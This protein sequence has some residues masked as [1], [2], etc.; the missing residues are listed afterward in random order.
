MKF[1]GPKTK[2]MIDDF[3]KTRIESLNLSTRTKNALINSSIRTIGGILRTG[4]SLMSDVD[5][6]GINGINEIKQVLSESFEIVVSNGEE[7]GEYLQFIPKYYESDDFVP[8][9][10]SKDWFEKKHQ[11]SFV[12]PRT[13]DEMDD[14]LKTRIELLGF[15]QRTKNALMNSSIRTVGG[16]LRNRATLYKVKGLGIKGVREITKELSKVD[17]I[18]IDSK[19]INLDLNQKTSV[20]NYNPDV[21]DI[22]ADYF[23]I[24]KENL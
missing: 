16:I 14:Y 19:K 15:S 23:D 11:V 8:E 21:V 7:K 1:A 12:C 4:G 6:V 22:F 24:P 18:E 13:K 17:S 5:G 2:E 9:E 10:T 3:L 20:I